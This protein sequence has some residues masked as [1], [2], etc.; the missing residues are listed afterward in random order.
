METNDLIVCWGL[1]FGILNVV[2]LR[3]CI[4]ESAAGI[5]LCTQLGRHTI[6]HDHLL[7]AFAAFTVVVRA[8][9]GRL[10]LRE[11]FVASLSCDLAL[12]ALHIPGF[13]QMIRSLEMR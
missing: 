9:D 3:L 11:L 1:A 2:A 12:E 13:R 4:T 8:P 7:R 5:M 10:G 6:E